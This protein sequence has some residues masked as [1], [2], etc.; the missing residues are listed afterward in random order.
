[1]QVTAGKTV[2]AGAT[3]AASTAI[4]VADELATFGILTATEAFVRQ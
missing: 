4:P 1:M 3:H 2:I